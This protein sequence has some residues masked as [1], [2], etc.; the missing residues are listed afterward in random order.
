[1]RDLGV[2]VVDT[3][4][5]SGCGNWGRGAGGLCKWEELGGGKGKRVGVE[6][7]V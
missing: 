1:M 5:L 4:G 3:E 7:G 6:C 2:R